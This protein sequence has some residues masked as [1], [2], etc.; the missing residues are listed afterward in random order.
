MLIIGECINSTTPEILEAIEKRGGD[1]IQELAKGQVEAGANYIDVN[2]GARIKTERED[3]EWLINTVNEV[4][5]VPLSIDSANPDII[6]HG[7]EIYSGLKQKSNESEFKVMVNSINA[8][9]TH[10]QKVL[11]LVKEYDCDVIGLLI[12]ENGIPDK[13]EDRVSISSKIIDQLHEYEIPIDRLYL[14][15]VI[16]PIS[17]DTTKGITI[18]ETL[19]LVK[20]E[21]PEVKTVLGLSNISFGLPENELINRTFL[22]M[23]MVY[24]LDAAIMNPLD[25]QIIGSLQAAKML[26]NQDEFCMKYITAYRDGRLNFR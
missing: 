13:P 12:D 22:T 1:F 6:K 25:K 16:Q 20:Q 2:A 7:L 9:R 15:V 14:D 3:M 23:L 11:P 18:L 5:N 17:T 10:C 4:V 19:R 26:L 24:G 8:E 21:F